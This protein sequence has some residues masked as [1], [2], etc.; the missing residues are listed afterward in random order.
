[1][2]ESQSTDRSYHCDLCGLSFT[3]E[4]DQDPREWK[5]EEMDFEMPE[6]YCINCGVGIHDE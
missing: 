2:S 6:A 1:M 3:V 4:I 5:Y